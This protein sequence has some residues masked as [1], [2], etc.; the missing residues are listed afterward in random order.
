MSHNTFCSMFELVGS[1]QNKPWRVSLTG[2]NE[3]PF[4]LSFFVLQLR[5]LANADPDSSGPPWLPFSHGGQR[6]YSPR[7]AEKPKSNRNYLVLISVSPQAVDFPTHPAPSWS[8][9]RANHIPCSWHIGVSVIWLHPPAC[10]FPLLQ[11]SGSGLPGEETEVM[12][13]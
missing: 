10:V 4:P 2:H 11:S 9:V 8:E 7:E 1:F 5:F 6:H 3:L 12:N 13:W